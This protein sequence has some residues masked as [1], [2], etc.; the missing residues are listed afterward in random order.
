MRRLFAFDFST[1]D[2][3]VSLLSFTNKTSYNASGYKLNI[4][5]DDI[6]QSPKFTNSGSFTELDATTAG[7]AGD[8]IS[9]IA[10]GDA[11]LSANA[12]RYSYD[13]AT[14]D[15]TLTNL[16][17]GSSQ[18]IDITATLDAIGDGGD[19]DAGETAQIVFGTHNVTLTL[20]GD[21]SPTTNFERGTSIIT[22]GSLTVNAT[23]ITVN[24]RL[25]S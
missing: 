18:T 20:T 12:Y 6:F 23:N 9:A 21:G 13:S 5:F 4:N 15:L 22:T 10:F 17:T 7:P 24:G 25:A 16:T 19:L 1:S 11:V 8:G 3:R 14:E 2:P